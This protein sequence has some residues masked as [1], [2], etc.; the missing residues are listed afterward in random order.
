M[1]VM[2]FFIKNKSDFP[3]FYPNYTLFSP[4]MQTLITL[5]FLARTMFLIFKEL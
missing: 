1:Q 5:I 3:L 4:K 2:L